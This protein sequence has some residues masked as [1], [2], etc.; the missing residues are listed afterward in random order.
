MSANDRIKI[1]V[2]DKMLD[3]FRQVQ[4]VFPRDAAEVF[5]DRT[6]EHALERFEEFTF[7]I[8][9]LTGSVFK[10]Q[11]DGTF[12]LLELIATKSTITQIL[13]LI[14][15]RD[16]PLVSSALKAGSFQYAKLCPW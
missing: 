8:L 2:V 13:F 5:F 1:I 15:P 16:L 6:L 9:I 12:E 7:D 4:T 3:M 11:P 14:Y 10:H